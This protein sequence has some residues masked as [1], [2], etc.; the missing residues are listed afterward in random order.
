MS[1]AAR[2]APAGEPAAET[3]PPYPD[4]ATARRDAGESGVRALA[5]W[6]V[7]AHPPGVSSLTAAALELGADPENPRVTVDSLRRAAIRAGAPLPPYPR[8]A[9]AGSPKLA[10]RPKRTRKTV[11]NSRT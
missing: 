8:G 2:I 1:G 7:A 10:A 11:A 4:L 6:I 9:P 3:P 5:A